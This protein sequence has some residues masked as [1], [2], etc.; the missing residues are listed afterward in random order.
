MSRSPLS[1]SAEGRPVRGTGM[2]YPII[3][4]AVAI[5]LAPVIWH[6]GARLLQPEA[7][8][9][10]SNEQIAF[11]ETEIEALR[12]R[13]DDLEEAVRTGALSELERDTAPTGDTASRF[14]GFDDLMLLS[15]RGELNTG[16]RPLSMDTLE[17]VFGMPA[18]ELSQK[19]A[20]P[21]SEKLVA[22]LETRDVGPFRA[23]LIGPA[24][25]S[26]ERVLG[27]VKESYPALYRQLR[28]YGGF[29]A[30]LVRGSEDSISRHG[31][32]LAIDISIGGTLDTMGDGKT[33]FGLLILHEFFLEE[34]W[35]W[36][37]SFG[38]ED[39]MHFEVSA[40][41]LNR[42]RDEGLI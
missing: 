11:L 42:W 17:D 33:Q 29:C 31:F 34:G 7:P 37:A 6:L 15:A 32:G 35:V 39:S 41:L 38:R 3:L 36:G 27:T 28:N 9:R 16:L 23:R 4:L 5:M 25:D 2:R 1:N 12:N 26:L 40:E 19:C 20:P 21:S 24:L 18:P 14:G 30:R 10:A 8:G 13:L 22:L